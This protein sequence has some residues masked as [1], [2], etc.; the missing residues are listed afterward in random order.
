[1]LRHLTAALSPGP[2]LVVVDG[3]AHVNEFADR[4]ADAVAATSQH[5]VRLTADHVRRDVST[6]P[7]GRAIV[8]GARHQMRSGCPPEAVLIWLRTSSIDMLDSSEHLAQIVVDVVDPGWP[9]IRRFDESL[10]DRDSWYLAETQAF[11]AVRAATWDRKL[12]DDMP[13]YAAAV[14][15]TGVPSGGVAIDVGCGNGRALP[16]LR[17]AV[18]PTGTALGVDI[19]VEMLENALSLGRVERG[20][21]I[22]ADARRLPLAASSVDVVF[23]AGLIGHPPEAE[24]VL[25][26]L[27]RVT[28]PAGRLALFHPSGRAVRAARHGR[29]LKADETLAETVLSTALARAGWHLDRYDDA[30]ERFY[31]RATR[32]TAP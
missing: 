18:G 4:L 25:R 26:E 29:V 21:V 19:T 2:R 8:I 28:A 9:V 5:C 32:V 15:E 12:G 31:A 30:V 1:V 11:F 24:S 20:R 17:T 6:M 3:R 16:A 22:L 27:A 14:A 10:A 13:A 23:A 7:G